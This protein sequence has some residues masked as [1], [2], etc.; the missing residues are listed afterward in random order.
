MST[1]NKVLI[2]RWFDEVWNR[3]IESSI[4]ELM[5][6]EASVFGLAD[7]PLT[8]IRGPREFLPFWTRFTT[9]FPDMQIAVESTLAEEDQVVA[10][11]NV[12][13][14]HTGPGLEIPPTNK[15]VTF[16]G[17]CLAQIRDGKLYQAWNNFDFLLLHRQLGII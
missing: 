6:P 9:A 10:R 1:A 16:T 3:K 17:M 5:H 8:P 7:S 11:C 12:T 2:N 4:F 15:E 13:G 14:K